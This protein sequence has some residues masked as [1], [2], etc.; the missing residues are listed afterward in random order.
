MCK[1]I[2]FDKKREEKYGMKKLS[3]EV[4]D[5]V[6]FMMQVDSC[7]NRMEDSNWFVRKI[8]KPV[9]YWLVQSEYEYA[10]ESLIDEVRTLTE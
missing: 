10:R 7:L 3:V 5:G 2:S 1:V 6:R 4:S 9:F 8:V